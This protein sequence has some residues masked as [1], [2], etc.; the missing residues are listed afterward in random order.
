MHE[1]INEVS[2]QSVDAYLAKISF[3]E[4]NYYQL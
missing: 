2:Y 1:I 3:S 4:Q